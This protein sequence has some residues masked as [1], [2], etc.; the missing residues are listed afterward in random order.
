[1]AETSNQDVAVKRTAVKLL[2]TACDG[3]LDKEEPLMAALNAALRSPND[4]LFMYNYRVAEQEFRRLPRET[5]GT[6]MSRC[7]SQIAEN[8]EDI[9]AEIKVLSSEHRRIQRK[10]P[11]AP[12]AKKSE[13]KK[14]EPLK[15]ELGKSAQ[16]KPPRRIT[17]VEWT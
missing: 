3:L 4:P 17:A 8:Q 13:P 10:Q 15:H 12:E 16:P 14:P 9:L 6:L 7:Q 11:P 2:S 1:M 5:T